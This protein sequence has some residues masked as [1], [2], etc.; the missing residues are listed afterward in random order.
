MI[1]SLVVV[2]IAILFVPGISWCQRALLTEGA[3]L[4]GEGRIRLELGFGYTTQTYNF[5]TETFRDQFKI[6]VI[7]IDIGVGRIADIEV[8]FPST[9]IQDDNL[10]GVAADVGDATFFTKVRFLSETEYTPAVAIKLGTKLPNAEDEVGIG[11]NETDFIGSFPISKNFG[12]IHTRLELG[13]GILGDPRRNSAQDDVFLFGLGFLF[14]LR[15]NLHL[16]T[17]INGHEGP[18]RL[19]DLCVVRLGAQMELAGL[20]WD[21]SGVLGLVDESEDWGVE[22][23]VSLDFEAF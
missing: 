7:G 22:G 3:D 18:Q 11:T 20:R 4:V 8:D 12:P 5:R 16:L 17:E 13:I 19:D 14:R 21:L 15:S 23:G 1:R 9:I 2:C 6:G 10:K